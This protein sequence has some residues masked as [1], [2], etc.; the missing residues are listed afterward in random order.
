MV[1]STIARRTW[2]ARTPSSNE[3]PRA[4][5]SSQNLVSDR[6][7]GTVPLSSRLEARANGVASYEKIRSGPTTNFVGNHMTQGAIELVQSELQRTDPFLEARKAR[8]G[9]TTQRYAYYGP[10]GAKADSHLAV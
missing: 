8:M 2:R 3:M 9:L 6:R 5:K 7:P 4:M 1:E 10:L